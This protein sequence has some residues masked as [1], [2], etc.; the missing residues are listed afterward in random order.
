MSFSSRRPRCVM[1]RPANEI[2]PSDGSRRRTIIR[3]V[4][5]LPRPGLAYQ[6]EHLAALQRE[7]DAVDCSQR[8]AEPDADRRKGN[9]SP[10]RLRPQG[11]VAPRCRQSPPPSASSSRVTTR[12][13]GG[14][15]EWRT[16]RRRNGMRWRGRRQH[17]AGV[18]SPP[19]RSN[20]LGRADMGVEGAAWRHRPHA[21]RRTRDRRQPGARLAGPR[22][23]PQKRSGCTDDGDR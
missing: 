8:A 22:H 9:P 13:R 23:T 17:R 21:R 15:V 12:P 4:V 6:R 11:A 14:P 7:V 2:V 1:S 20:D 16:F 19:R 3:P 18:G 10:D 5:D